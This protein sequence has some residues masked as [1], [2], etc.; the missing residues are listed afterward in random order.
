MNQ[1]SETDF[2]QLLLDLGWIEGY[3]ELEAALAVAHE[4]GQPIGRVFIDR[5]Y[6]SPREVQNLIEVQ[7]LIRDNYLTAAEGRRAVSF[8]SWAGVSIECAVPFTA[9]SDL[10]PEVPYHNRLGQLLVAAGYLNDE[11]VED[12]LISSQE[13]GL[14]LGKLFTLRNYLCKYSLSAVLEAQKLIRSDLVT[15]EQATTGLKVLRLGFQRA[16]IESSAE[17]SALPLGQLFSHAGVVTDK[18]IEDALEVSKINRQPLGQVLLIFALL[19]DR[20]LESALEL[21]KLIRTGR[22]RRSSAVRAL[23]L[24]YANGITLQ[25]ALVQVHEI[26]GENSGLTV[27]TFLQMTGLFEG[28]LREIERIGKGAFQSRQ[29]LP[30]LSAFVDEASLRAAVRCTFLV[31]HSI[32]TLEQALLAFHCSILTHTDIDLFLERTGWVSQNALNLIGKQS[33]ERSKTLRVVA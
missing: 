2:G 30:Q 12:A 31:R 4:T 13:A 29:Q 23:N 3:E 8:S 5:G 33:Q 11:T 17:T 1:T 6:L 26:S 16:A 28:H 7:A 32:L 14:Q 24:I 15:W 19:S 25:E 20:L 9:P 22:L 10:D 27:S 21:Q 18:H